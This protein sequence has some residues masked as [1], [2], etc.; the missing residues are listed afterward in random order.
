MHLVI[1]CCFGSLHENKAVWG[2][3][4]HSYRTSYQSG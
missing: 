3:S 2:T 4:V 1:E